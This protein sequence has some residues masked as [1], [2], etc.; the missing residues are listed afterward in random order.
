MSFHGKATI[1]LPKA[2][3]QQRDIAIAKFED[4]RRQLFRAGSTSPDTQCTQPGDSTNLTIAIDA[5]NTNGEAVFVAFN[6]RSGIW[7]A[8][9]R[10]HEI[11]A[12][13]RFRR[14]EIKCAGMT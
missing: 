14:V 11:I 5:A 3:K 10:L 13:P 1:T 4:F 8:L 6:Y 2:R 12:V 9:D 7:K